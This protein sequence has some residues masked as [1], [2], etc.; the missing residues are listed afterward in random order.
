MVRPDVLNRIPWHA[1]HDGLIGILHDGDAAGVLDPLQPVRPVVEAARQHDAH[2]A[3]LVIAGRR[4]EEGIDGG[5]E[6]VFFGPSTE[7]QA[8]APDLDV[9]IRR[10]HIDVPGAQLLVVFRE[11]DRQRRPTRQNL[12]EITSGIGS[13]MNRDHD[14]GT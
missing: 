5:P 4:S 11:R 12:W 6:A 7:M 13:R 8:F 9:K 3:R 1:G 10:G 2:H 14:G